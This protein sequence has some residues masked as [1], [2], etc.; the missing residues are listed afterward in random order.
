MR[1]A[2]LLRI[3]HVM[4]LHRLYWVPRAFAARQGAYVT[5]RAEELHAIFNI[6]SHRNRTRLV[7]ENLGTVPPVVNENMKRHGMRGMY[8]VQFE[9]RADPKAALAPPQSQSVASLNTHDTP[10]FAAH[11]RGDDL[12][13]SVRLELL[14]RRQLKAAKQN[15][16][17]LKGALVEFLKEQ[18]FLKNLKPGPQEVLRGVLAWLKAGKSELVLINLEDLWLETRPQNVP[19]TSTERPNWRRK[20]RVSLEKLLRDLRFRRLVPF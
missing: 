20:A 5:Y 19:G 12:L 4:G 9:E 8:V 13:E 15:R 14:P 6:E 3:D 2:R 17:N 1:Y 11:W 10:T 18:G 16:E 7:G